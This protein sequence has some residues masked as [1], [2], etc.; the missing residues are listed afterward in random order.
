MTACGDD[1][2]NLSAFSDY[3]QFTLFYIYDGQHFNSPVEAAS[4][5]D[6]HIQTD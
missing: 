5:Q 6:E 3:G 2:I 4:K 1:V